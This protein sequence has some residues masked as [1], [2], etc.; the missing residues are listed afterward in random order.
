MR[1]K[2][3]GVKVG[4]GVWVTV[5][6]IVG[7]GVGVEDD[8]TVISKRSIYV[9]KDESPDAFFLTCILI[10]LFDWLLKFDKFDMSVSTT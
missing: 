7:V 8:D 3:V 1:R 6:V 2:T 5:G 10:I 9:V 4:V